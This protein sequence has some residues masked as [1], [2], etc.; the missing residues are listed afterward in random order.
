MER[1]VESMRTTKVCRFANDSDDCRIEE[2]FSVFSKK[3]ILRE[4]VEKLKHATSNEALS[5]FPDFSMKKNVLKHLRYIDVEDVV[6]IK[7]R[8]ACEV[9]T[10]EESLIVTEM[11]FEGILN[12]L[13]PASIVAVLS[14]LI[15][16][17]SD[18]RKLRQ[19]DVLFGDSRNQKKTNRFETYLIPEK[20]GYRRFGRRFAR[21][22]VRVL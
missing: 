6:Q 18:V 8:V 7:G 1:L 2:V 4:K 10:C 15:F 17:V 20:I 19:K 21:E 14:A 11:V 13:E 5:L 3:E 22:F 16:Q 9:N 12:D